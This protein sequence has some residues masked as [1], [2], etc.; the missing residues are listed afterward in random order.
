MS[1]V[2]DAYDNIEAYQRALR[3]LDQAHAEITAL[4]E[5]EAEYECD[6]NHPVDAVSDC[7]AYLKDR[8][9]ALRGWIAP[10]E[11]EAA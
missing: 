3:L 5:H 9:D 2:A 11:R 7:R 8:I 10:R 4:P 6:G 1:T